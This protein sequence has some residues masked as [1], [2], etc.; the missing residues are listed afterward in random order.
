MDTRDRIVLAAS[1]ELREF[2][3]S[4]FRVRRVAKE[5]GT[6]I[7]LLYSYFKDRD[8][9]IAAAV[10]SLYRENLN[11]A[12]REICVPLEGV[13]TV[14]DFRRA[15]HI[16]VEGSMGTR[17]RTL[18]AQR[19]SSQAFAEYNAVARAGLEEVR[20]EASTY[21]FERVHPLE[22]QGLLSPALSARSFARIWLALLSLNAFGGGH[23]LSV[24]AEEWR[25]AMNLLAEAAVNQS[26]TS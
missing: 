12:V 5:A 22:T 14:E 2:G 19:Q 1:E 13:R 25:Q 18:R 26:A 11:E 9:V 17:L 24:D 3:I 6:S 8:D 16:M 7:A 10:I 20:T 15:L 21:F 23:Q 4:K